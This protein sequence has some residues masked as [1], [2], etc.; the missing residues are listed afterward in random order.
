[1]MTS[2][3][4]CRDHTEIPSMNTRYLTRFL[5]VWLIINGFAYQTASFTGLLLPGHAGMVSNIG[6]PALPGELAFML[7]ILIKGA[8]VQLGKEQACMAGSGRGEKVK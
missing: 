2:P 1:M 3:T 7:W 4:F 8:N 5:A 6:W